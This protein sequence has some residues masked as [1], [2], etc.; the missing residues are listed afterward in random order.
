MVK[1]KKQRRK[2]RRLKPIPKLILWLLIL[3]CLFYWIIPNVYHY[4]ENTFLSEEGQ[5]NQD[6]KKITGNTILSQPE[7]EL[8]VVDIQSESAILIDLDTKQPVYKK[9]A[10]QLQYPASLTKIMTVYVAIKNGINWE[11]TVTLPKE[12]FANVYEEHASVAGFTPGETCTLSDLLYGTI[13]PS[14]ADAAQALAIAVAGSE[15][16]FVKQMNETAAELHMEHT[17][18]CNVTGLHEEQQQTTAEDFAI[19]LNAA[20]KLPEFREIFT[21]QSYT[22]TQTEEHPEGIHLT[23]TLAWFMETYEIDFD[24]IL[25][26]KTGSTKEAGLCLASLLSLDGKEFICVT[27]HAPETEDGQPQHILDTL[28]IGQAYLNAIKKSEA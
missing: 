23:S 12:A 13:L 16:E 26:G 11:E 3:F 24:L 25:G 22:T 2:R 7:T 9:N 21:T 19:L 15:E 10:T 18:F 5:A 14:G 4:V 8:S 6:A 17:N 1:K 20:L 27:L 28:A